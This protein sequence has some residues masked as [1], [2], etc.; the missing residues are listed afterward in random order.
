LHSIFWRLDFASHILEAWRKFVNC[1][2]GSKPSL[3]TSSKHPRFGVRNCPPELCSGP[4]MEPVTALPRSIP[5]FNGNPTPPSSPTADNI[6]YEAAREHHEAS[7][8]AGILVQNPTDKASTYIN[9]PP[10]PTT[11]SQPAKDGSPARSAVPN[12]Q[13]GHRFYS[14]RNPVPKVEHFP[15]ESL[16]RGPVGIYHSPMGPRQQRGSSS[17]TTSHL[18]MGRGAAIVESIP[19][20]PTTDHRG[21]GGRKSHGE[22]LDQVSDKTSLGKSQSRREAVGGKHAKIV[23][24]PIT[25][26]E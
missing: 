13:G 4:V 16:Y 24:D 25:H 11:T 7:S 2:V 15:W 12:V 6:D 9:F 22:G 10:A 21:H 3:N 14:E 20:S 26:E 1:Q 23:I 18:G 5:T 17:S 8:S 19:V